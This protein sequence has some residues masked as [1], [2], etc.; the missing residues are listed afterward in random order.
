MF[1]TSRHAATDKHHS[2]ARRFRTPRV[3]PVAGFASTPGYPPGARRQARPWTP[4][5][6]SR[7]S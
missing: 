5:G 3:C 7:T 1:K 4:P 6:T 2:L